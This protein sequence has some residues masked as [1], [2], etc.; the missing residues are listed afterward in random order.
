[1]QINKSSEH[2]YR[3]ISTHLHTLSKFESADI[4]LSTTMDA[5]DTKSVVANDSVSTTAI[6]C[7]SNLQPYSERMYT[8]SQQSSRSVITVREMMRRHWLLLYYAYLYQKLVNER[9]YFYKW[10]PT[11][12][13]DHSLTFDIRPAVERRS[14]LAELPWRD[15]RKFSDSGFHG[16]RRKTSAFEQRNRHRRR[17][18]SAGKYPQHGKP[19]PQGYLAA[20]SDKLKSHRQYFNSNPFSTGT[21]NRKSNAIAV[22]KHP[23][24]QLCELHGRNGL[25]IECEFLGDR[26]T[27]RQKVTYTVMS[28]RFSAVSHTRDEAKRLAAKKA[29]A[30]LHPQLHDEHDQVPWQEYDFG[31]RLNRRHPVDLV[32]HFFRNEP[33]VMEINREGFSHFT[34]YT[35]T[36]T[37]RGRQYMATAEKQNEA[38]RRCAILVL[39]DLYRNSSTYLPRKCHSSDQGHQIICYGNTP[40][41]IRAT[42]RRGHKIAREIK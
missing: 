27:R 30:T 21:R 26:P 33:I 28:R 41:Q 22:R 37:V 6:L 9:Y 39:N 1:M 4:S 10:R 20:Q 8:L 11:C 15:Q 32:G 7:S 42:R 36:Y 14:P 3:Q 31:D 25:R 34:N 17:R 23:V 40:P 12:R 13:L 35:V 38:K 19:R 24:Q 18:L 5:V 16:Q 29:L 2:S